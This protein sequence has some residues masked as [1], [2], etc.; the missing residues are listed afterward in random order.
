M[1]NKKWAILEQSERT[2]EI[3]L[4]WKDKDTL[5]IRYPYLSIFQKRVTIWLYCI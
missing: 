3:F 5:G 2:G 4:K 1:M